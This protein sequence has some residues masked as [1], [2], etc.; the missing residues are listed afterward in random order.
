MMAKDQDPPGTGGTRTDQT[1]PHRPPR[2]T[3]D[4]RAASRAPATG[5]R[6]PA[7][8]D[9]RDP[10]RPAAARGRHPDGKAGQSG[11]GTG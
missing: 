7:A 5:D 1:T 6:P 10:A 3:E 11:F 8:D 9:P 2:H 4:D